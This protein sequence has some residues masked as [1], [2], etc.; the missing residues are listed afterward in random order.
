MCS[1]DL[2]CRAFY[3]RAFTICPICVS[4]LHLT[5]NRFLFI[6]AI[7]CFLLSPLV[8]KLLVVFCFDFLCTG[9]KFRGGILLWGSPGYFLRLLCKIPL[10]GAIIC[11][12]PLFFKIIQTTPEKKRKLFKLPPRKM[13]LYKLPLLKYKLPRTNTDYPRTKQPFQSSTPVSS[14]CEVQDRISCS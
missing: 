4:S 7:G 3:R 8:G 5:R 13:K 14:P 6:F 11:K 12:I 9:A 1:S 10:W 2:R